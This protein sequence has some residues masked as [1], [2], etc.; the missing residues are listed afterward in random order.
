[1]ILLL[2]HPELAQ[3][4]N[5]DP[6]WLQSEVPGLALLATIIQRLREYPSSLGVLLE[7]FRDSPHIKTLSMLACLE[8]PHESDDPT[9]RQTIWHDMLRHLEA[10]HHRERLR[11]LTAQPFSTLQPHERLELQQLSAIK[12]TP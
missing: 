8:P 6:H 3:T 2:H 11:Q 12:T 7:H 5:T 1:M 4:Q 10:L 9:M